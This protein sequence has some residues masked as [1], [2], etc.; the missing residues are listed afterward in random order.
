[1][2]EAKARTIIDDTLTRLGRLPSEPGEWAAVLVDPTL[3]ERAGYSATPE[4][5]FAGDAVAFIMYGRRL[6]G[7]EGSGERRSTIT[8]R[9]DPLIPPDWW[10]AESQRRLYALRE[11]R[12][13]LRLAAGLL[14]QLPLGS[15]AEIAPLVESLAR[16][17]R[18][19]FMT[20]IRSDQSWFSVLHSGEAGGDI[21]GHEDWDEIEYPSESWEQDGEEEVLIYPPGAMAVSE[22]TPPSLGRLHR[23]TRRVAE[24]LGITQA[25]CL[26]WGL[27]DYPFT[28]PW[29]PLAVRRERTRDGDWSTVSI[30]VNSVSTTAQAVAKAYTLARGHDDG[31]KTAQRAPRPWPALVVAFVQQRQKVAPGETW[32][33]RFEAFTKTH[34][35]HPYK[36]VRT[37]AEAYRVKARG[38]KP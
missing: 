13:S 6:R 25:D 33:E 24:A 3:R 37:F 27:T 19:W 14:D 10:E 36:T 34:P 12:V 28:I 22:E 7:G 8:R 31:R 16:R 35:D 9:V 29:M 26:V 20:S 30:Q 18:D 2:D 1:M 11:E 38:A 15:V 5:D 4:E 21:P 17:Q 23:R 32:Q